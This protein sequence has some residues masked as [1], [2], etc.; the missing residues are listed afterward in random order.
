[1]IPVVLGDMNFREAIL[2]G[3]RRQGF[4]VVTARSIGF[5]RTADDDIYDY[6]AGRGWA[7]ASHDRDFMR[8]GRRHE[9][10]GTARVLVLHVDLYTPTG[11]AVRAIANQLRTDPSPGVRYV[12]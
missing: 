8:I 3:L 4:E 1:M 2:E 6:A 12:T 10:A 11:R 9:I 7:I 5:Q